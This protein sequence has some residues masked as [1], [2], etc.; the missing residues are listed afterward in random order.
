MSTAN[1]LGRGPLLI[2][3]VVGCVLAGDLT[4]EVIRGA[5]YQ[6]DQEEEKGEAYKGY[7]HSYANRA[8]ASH[9]LERQLPMSQLPC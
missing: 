8:Y 3:S 5:I 1:E 6:L 7:R 9:R 2:G 4:G